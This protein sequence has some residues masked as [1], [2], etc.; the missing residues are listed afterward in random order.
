MRVHFQPYELTPKHG[1]FDQVGE[2][3]AWE[4]EWVLERT[5]RSPQ[6]LLPAIR[7]LERLRLLNGLSLLSF[8]KARLKAKRFLPG[9]LKY[10]CLDGQYKCHSFSATHLLQAIERSNDALFVR[11]LWNCI[12]WHFHKRRF[13]RLISHAGA[14]SVNVVTQ[15]GMS[16][17]N[18]F[19]VVC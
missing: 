3:L 17:S 6:H 1:L 2:A 10:L 15:S 8:G 9:Q 16:Y 19:N 18:C 5:G 11:R 7:R 14:V 12:D 13:L 4:T